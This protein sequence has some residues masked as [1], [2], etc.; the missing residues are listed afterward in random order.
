MHRLFELSLSLQTS[1]ASCAEAIELGDADAG[2][3][4]LAPTQA[5][6]TFCHDLDTSSCFL[7]DSG[8]PDCLSSF[9]F[10]SDVTLNAAIRRFTDATCSAIVDLQY[11][12]LHAA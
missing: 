9:A 12:G 2:V 3:M 11:R 5:A 7:A 1:E 4:A 8:A 10:F 6:A